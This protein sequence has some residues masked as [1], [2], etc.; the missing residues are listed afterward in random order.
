MSP[1]RR[2]RAVTVLQQRFGVSQR[3]ACRLAGQHRSA[4]RRP[5]PVPRDAD[6]VLRARLRQISAQYPRWGWRKAHAI[7]AREGLVVN[8]KRTRRLWLDEGLKRPPRVRKKR[9]NP[10]VARRG[11]RRERRRRLDRPGLQ[12]AYV[13]VD[14]RPWASRPRSQRCPRVRGSRRCRSTD[15]V[16]DSDGLVEQL[17]D[18][19]RRRRL[20]HSGISSLK[21]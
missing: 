2:R 8:R 4:Q 20:S 18:Q 9:R 3:R 5:A 10:T 6:E 14:L 16:G 13:T 19:I 12:R 21:K 17:E 11:S 1:E 15:S 7:A